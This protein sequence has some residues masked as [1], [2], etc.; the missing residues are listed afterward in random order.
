MASF[1]GDDYRQVYQFAKQVA[2]AASPGES[3]NDRALFREARAI[4]SKVELAVGQLSGL[5][6]QA[7][8]KGSCF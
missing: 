6:A 4:A 1:N 8:K 5:P 2:R 7:W 3:A